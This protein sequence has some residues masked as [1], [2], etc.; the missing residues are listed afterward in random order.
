MNEKR[1]SVKRIQNFDI[2]LT[3]DTDHTFSEEAILSSLQHE[4]LE[5]VE[6]AIL[7]YEIM[8]VKYKVWEYSGPEAST[9]EGEL[10]IGAVGNPADA[11]T[12]VLEEASLTELNSEADHRE[13]NLSSDEQNQGLLSQ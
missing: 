2:D 4:E 7:R 10:K 6:T 12:L 1:F 13:W 11:T 5:A 3:D 8:A 9:F